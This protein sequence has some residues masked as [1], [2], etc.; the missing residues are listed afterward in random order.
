MKTNKALQED[1]KKQF[2]IKVSSGINVVQEGLNRFRIDTPFT[3]DDGDNLVIVLKRQNNEWYLS[4][5]GHTYMHL[6]YRMDT[7][8][9]QKGNR[10]KIIS[11][12]LSSFEISDQDG[13][14]I[15][16]IRN[17]DYGNAL[18]SFIQGLL[19]IN[20]ITFLNKEIIRS[21]F[22]EDFRE[23]VSHTIP[24]NRLEF[25]YYDEENDPAGNYMVDCKINGMPK[26][27]FIFA[28]SSDEKTRDATITLHQYERSGYKFQS[29]GIFQ[30]QESINRKVLARF[31]D[32]VDRQ[33][34]SL[35]GN[36]DRIERHLSELIS[37]RV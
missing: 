34:S 22:I 31:T 9:L 4:D 23:F 26:P 7:K 14:L 25:G 16:P 10:Q 6:S 3:F 29:V 21:T 27:V 18:F 35:S 12:I 2:H 20:D 11:D 24:E 17:S 5:E 37:N 32:I 28:L 13:E 1:I 15:N 33:F 36:R 19:K 30:D 8:V